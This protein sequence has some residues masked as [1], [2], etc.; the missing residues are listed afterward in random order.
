MK[1]KTKYG[2]FWTIIILLGVSAIAWAA[3][4]KITGMTADTS[5][6][7]DDL[8]TTVDDPSGTPANKK[9]TISD[10]FSLLVG[11]SETITAK[12]SLANLTLTA[13][14]SE[15]S[16]LAVGDIVKADNDTWDPCGI[17]GTDDY[18]A[19]VTATGSPN[20]YVALLDDQGNW[21]F[22]TIQAAMNVITSAVQ[23]TLTASE[24]NSVIVM[25]AA[26]DVDIPADQCDTATGKW[27]TVKTT[28]T[29]L[30][31][32]TSNDASDQ[33]VLSDGTALTAGNELDLGGAA[34]N[35]ATVMCLEANKWYVT[36]EIGTCVDGGAAD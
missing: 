25:T 8:I 36:G 6:S 13:Q 1:T 35:Q 24:M 34:G 16:G 28:G 10:L 18:L 21:Y 11:T 19:M 27:I 32:I 4:L 12:W 23:K 22:N 15:P 30:N 14:T 26:G 2:F 31:S 7:T 5:P 33:F 3:S 20:T 17:S 29:F 9:V